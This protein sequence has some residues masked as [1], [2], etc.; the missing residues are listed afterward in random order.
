[1]VGRPVKAVFERRVRFEPGEAALEIRGLYTPSG[2]E[3]ID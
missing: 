3:N 2:L 1:M